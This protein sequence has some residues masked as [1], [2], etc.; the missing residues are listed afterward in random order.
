MMLVD[1]YRPQ[2]PNALDQIIGQDKIIAVSKRWVANKDMPHVILVGPPGCGKTTWAK[3]MA[4]AMF[5]GFDVWNEKHPD[6]KEF[7]ASDERGIDVVRGE[8]KEFAS[9][10]PAWDVPFRICFLDEADHVTGDAQHAMR[11]T[12]E[13]YED[14]CRFFMSGNRADYIEAMLSRAATFRFQAIPDEWMGGKIW[15]I[16]NKEGI[17]LGMKGE[18]CPVLDAIV[19]FYHGD[20]RRAINDC[21]EKLRGID[22]PVTM[23]DLD[24]GDDISSIVENVKDIL[25]WPITTD[26][27]AMVKYNAARTFFEKEH[28]R[29][30]FDVRDFIEQLHAA[31]GPLAFPAARAFSEADDRIRSGGIKDVHVGYLLAAIADGGNH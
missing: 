10:G 3:G 4:S 23:A 25:Q 19:K 16:A 18:R 13:K 22:H 26:K 27:P 28:A 5:N 31:M 7:N 12:V 14:R 20:L 2:G 11:N 15:E 9:A 30:Q 21:L 17:I 6:F 1:K 29:L 24:F 8:I